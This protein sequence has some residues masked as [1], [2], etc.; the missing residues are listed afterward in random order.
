ME[1]QVAVSKRDKFFPQGSGDT[2]E[3]IERP[4]GGISVV[5]ADGK[6]DLSDSKLVSN[7]VVHRVINL[8]SEGMHDGSAARSA[9]SMLFR[10]FSGKASASLIIL[11]CD[12]QS[13]TIVITRCSSAPI[14]I[15]QD[16]HLTFLTSEN[17]SIGDKEWTNPT[18]TEIPILPDT[19]VI[20]FTDGILYAGKS[21]GMG[22]DLVTTFNALFDDQEPSA[23]E[24][25]E[26][27]LA[28]AVGLDQGEPENDMCVAA[29]QVISE[30]D[31]P[32]RRMTVRLPIQ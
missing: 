22:I 1:I 29:L 26:F 18:I 30:S 15:Y 24:I 5:V 3:I 20:M 9:A 21:N 27:L 23:Q 17:A 10:D 19:S 11:S 12:Y 2:L 32:V 31:D 8:I 4:N 25:T 28:Q 14:V 7:K 16:D 6:L 13:A